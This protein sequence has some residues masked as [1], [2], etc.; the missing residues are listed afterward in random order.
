M[1]DKTYYCEAALDSTWISS[2][3]SSSV[4]RQQGFYM[5]QGCTNNSPSWRAISWAP[6]RNWTLSL[7]F[8]C[9]DAELHSSLEMLCSVLSRSRELGFCQEIP[10]DGDA[11]HVS[12]Y[13]NSTSAY[14]GDDTDSGLCHMMLL[15][16]K[17]GNSNRFLLESEHKDLLKLNICG[18]NQV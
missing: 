3:L 11:S 14:S 6:G 5:G 12:F 15:L 4:N 13:K 10:A 7:W 16:L 8:Y 1:K 17:Q 18:I 2:C 9:S